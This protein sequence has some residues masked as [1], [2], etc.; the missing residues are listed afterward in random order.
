MFEFLASQE[1]GLAGLAL[2]S[3]LSATLLPGSSEVLL[4]LL[5]EQGR[6]PVIWLVVV[7]SLANTAGGM[8]T[9]LLGWWSERALVKRGRYQEPS[10]QSLAWIR[11]WGAG[12]LLLS[13]VPVI[14]DGLCL[15]GG[16]L[17]LPWL[18]SLV[19]MLLGKSIRYIALAYGLQ[20]MTQ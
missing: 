2:S 7:A 8:S 3:F 13:W 1:A 20:L 10:G 14:G 6:I 12:A 16:W 19:A 9:F 11:R 18:P 15:A 17:R 5:L 4:L